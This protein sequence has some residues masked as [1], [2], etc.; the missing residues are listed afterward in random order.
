MPAHR[1]AS[2]CVDPSAIHH[3]APGHAVTA[4]RHI[5]LPRRTNQQRGT[6]CFA[7]CELC[8]VGS[9]VRLNPEPVLVVEHDGLVS[10]R[11]LLVRIEETPEWTYV[12]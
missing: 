7:E 12:Q 3:A 2:D 9:V 10:P 5:E 4:L 8:V 11:D 1:A 6:N